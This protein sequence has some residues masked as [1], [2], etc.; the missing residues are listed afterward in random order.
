MLI[1]KHLLWNDNRQDTNMFIM[2]TT[3]GK[4]KRHHLTSR[5]YFGVGL[6]RKSN[7]VCYF[8]KK[9]LY[10]IV[11]LS[12]EEPA[13]FYTLNSYMFLFFQPLVKWSS[14][15]V[16]VCFHYNWVN[17]AAQSSRQCLGRGIIKMIY[18]DC[19]FP[20]VIIWFYQNKSSNSQRS[21]WGLRIFNVMSNLPIRFSSREYIRKIS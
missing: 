11:L 12:F 14:L 3:G 20:I 7:F 4:P 21:C 2:T 13:C 19:N 8:S 15:Y 16:Y 6:I 1:A 17:I 9:I 18:F 10:E 5:K